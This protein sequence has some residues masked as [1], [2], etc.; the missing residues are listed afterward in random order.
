MSRSL[1]WYEHL[2]VLLNAT[3]G[4]VARIKQRLYPLGVSTAAGD[5]A[6]TWIS[7]HHLPPQSG[8]HAQQPW[9]LET[10][11]VPERL[12]WGKAHGASSLWDEV[13]ILQ[14]QLQSQAQVTETLRQAVQ[15]L[16]EEQEQQKY[17]ICT[18]EASLRLLQGSPEQRVLLLD[19]CLEGLRRELQ[20]LRSQVQE[21]AQ[22]QIQTGPQKRSATGGLHQ[23]LQ[24]ECQLLWEESEI[25]QE[26]LKLL[27]DQLSQHQELLLK[28]M[29]E[30]GQAQA[31]SWKISRRAHFLTWSPA[32]FS[33]R[34]RAL[35]R[36]TY[37][38]RAPQCS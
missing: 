18:L 8:V 26:E 32:A 1:S 9:A 31:H 27:Q 23:E 14:S 12:S 24:N 11:F 33:F 3:D 19:Q 38:L 35:S 7:P 29:A 2:D 22:A 30:G 25:L 17:K 37:S 4:N 34:P 36:R 13:I 16:L 10:P 21:Q 6:G 15:G 20:G 28:Q 5:L